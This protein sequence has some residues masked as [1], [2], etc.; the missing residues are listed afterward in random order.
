MRLLTRLT[1]FSLLLVLPLAFTVTACADN[2]EPVVDSHINALTG[3]ACVPNPETY[4]DRTLRV[5]TTPIDCTGH[6]TDID[7]PDWCCK[8]PQPGCDADG[9]CDEDIVEPPG[10]DID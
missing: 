4:M 1:R 10:P 3:A 8:F 5:R 2:D 6:T 7:H 9:C